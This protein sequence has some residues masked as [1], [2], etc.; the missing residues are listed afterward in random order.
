[1]FQFPPKLLERPAVA[2]S[3]N[4]R[5]RLGRHER[6]TG[7]LSGLLA[8]TLGMDRQQ[9]RLMVKAAALHDVGKFYIS[10]A[11][12]EK[13]GPLTDDE[14]QMVQLHPLVGHVHLKNFTSSPVVDLAALIALEHHERWDGKGY[15]CKKAGSDIGLPSR[16]T[17]ICDVYSALREERP[18][19]SGLS[20]DEAMRALMPQ[21]GPRAKGQ[22]DPMVAAALAKCEH[23]F[24]SIYDRSL[25]GTASKAQP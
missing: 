5:R 3:S 15:P 19:K 21:E 11:V 16:I 7:L 14:T 23:Q 1:M 22:F 8:Q 17:S 13:P 2:L 6:M 24:R 10:P 25:E 12:L 20:H 18:Y 9:C 4:A